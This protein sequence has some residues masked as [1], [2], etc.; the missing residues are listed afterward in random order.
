MVAW[1]WDPAADRVTTSANL[2]EV[3]GVAAIE[4]AEQAFG[5]IHPDDLAAHR[6]I[7]RRP[8]SPAGAATD[9]SFG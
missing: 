5:M 9:P 6:A 7:D 1:E 8:P 4:S 2:P 3:Y